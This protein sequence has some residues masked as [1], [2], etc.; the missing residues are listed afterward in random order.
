MKINW[1]LGL[2]KVFNHI[3]GLSPFP[4]AWTEFEKLSDGQVIS[5]K[6]FKTQKI[7]EFHNFEVGRFLSD[8]KNNLDIYL[9][10]GKIRIERLQLSGKNRMSVE[11]FLRGFNIPDYKLKLL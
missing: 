10:D 11:D 3:R 8:E 6:I 5:V 1:D 7:Y 2:D 9:H 4:G